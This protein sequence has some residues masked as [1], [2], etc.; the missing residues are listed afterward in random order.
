[1]RFGVITTIVDLIDPNLNEKE[2]PVETLK[3]K[4]DDIE[5][6]SVIDYSFH[7]A[8]NNINKVK[9]NIDKAIKKIYIN[10]M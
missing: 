1:M 4:F 3:Y 7:M 2:K 6:N 8:L 9:M 10:M 5:N